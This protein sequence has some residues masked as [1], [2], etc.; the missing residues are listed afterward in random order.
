MVTISGLK[1]FT[2]RRKGKTQRRKEELSSYLALPSKS[3]LSANGC[4]RSA[5]GAEYEARGKRAAR[6]P[7]KAIKKFPALKLPRYFGLSGLGTVCS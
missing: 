1:S 3:K 6:R 2:Q 5:N 7:W 4:G